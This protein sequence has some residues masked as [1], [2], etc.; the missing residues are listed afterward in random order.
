MFKQ[1]RAESLKKHYPPH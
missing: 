1:H